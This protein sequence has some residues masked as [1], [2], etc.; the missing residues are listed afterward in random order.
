MCIRSHLF[1]VFK[2]HILRLAVGFP[3]LCENAIKGNT[4]L[5]AFAKNFDSVQW[6]TTQT[7]DHIFQKTL[8]FTLSFFQKTKL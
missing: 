3:D 6:S 8:Q 1:Y 5:L 7:S 2:E 4:R